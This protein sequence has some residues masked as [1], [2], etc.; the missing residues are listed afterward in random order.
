MRKKWWYGILGYV[1]LMTGAIVTVYIAT[2]IW[3]I[4]FELIRAYE[5]P[6]DLFRYSSELEMIGFGMAFGVTFIFGILIFL[7]INALLEEEKRQEI[8]KRKR[9]SNLIIMKQWV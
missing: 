1:F 6:D 8:E 9:K 4:S 2:L 5:C 3:N 7:F